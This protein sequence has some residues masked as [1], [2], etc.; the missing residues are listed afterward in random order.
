[1]ATFLN[2]QRVSTVKDLEEKGTAYYNANRDI[3]ALR[4]K[5]YLDIGAA[6]NW[7]QDKDFTQIP[8][9]SKKYR[10]K[11]KENQDLSRIQKAN[12]VIHRMSCMICVIWI[13][14]ERRIWKDTSN[15][16]RE[17]IKNI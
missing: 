12:N 7:G 15:L 5:L 10:D 17:L 13:Q 9:P 1:M 14:K 2:E 11:E 16:C 6:A 3:F 4:A 8:G